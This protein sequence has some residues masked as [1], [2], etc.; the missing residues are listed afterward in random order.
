MTKFYLSYGRY[1]FLTPEEYETISDVEDAI[2]DAE[3]VIDRLH[4]DFEIGE[5]SEKEM[6]SKV[7][8]FECFIEEC[9]SEIRHREYYESGDAYWDS[10]FDSYHEE[11]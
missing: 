6:E 4:E 2:Y 11:F 8:E 5:I 3:K 7:E 1:D 9:E 10:V